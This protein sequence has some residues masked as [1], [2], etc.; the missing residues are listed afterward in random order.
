MTKRPPV[1]FDRAACLRF[2]EKTFA[3]PPHWSHVKRV[4]GVGDC[5]ARFVLP[6]ELCLSS[7]VR[8]QSGVASAGWL[9]TKLRKRAFSEIAAQYGAVRAPSA[10]PGRPMVRAVRFSSVRVENVSDWSKNPIDRLCPEKRYKRN[11]KLCVAPGIGLIRDD[12]DDCIELVKWA[13]Y[14]PPKKGFAYIDVWTNEE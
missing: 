2:A 6:L 9:L 14:A 1:P 3:Q 5:V 12:A 8:M 13:E 11:G 10:L 7:N 4:A